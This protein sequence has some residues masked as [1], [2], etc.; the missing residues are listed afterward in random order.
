MGHEIIVRPDKNVFLA[1]ALLHAAGQGPLLSEHPIKEKFT[2]LLKEYKGENYLLPSL[3][4]LALTLNEAPDLSFRKDIS[5]SRNMQELVER[6]KHGQ[7]ALRTFYK[8]TGFEEAYQE[9]L[10]E[11]NQICEEMRKVVAVLKPYDNLDKIWRLT[12]NPFTK[13]VLIPMPLEGIKEASGPSVGD[14]AY[15]IVGPPFGYLIIDEI[16]HEAM[17][18]RMERKIT[19][20]LTE[21][22]E[23]RSYMMGHVRAN[24]FYPPQYGRNWVVC[25]EEHFIRAM[26]V[27]FF[28]ELDFRV[29]MRLDNERVQGFILVKTFYEE[30]DSNRK[31]PNHDLTDV[32]MKILERLDLEYKDKK[33]PPRYVG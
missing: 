17:H 19:E 9:I 11:Y 29:P 3:E 27:A 33:V 25:F 31:G 30:I 20:G 7:K 13:D 16:I 10:P 23:K 5:L 18:P 1:Y 26:Q 12:D 2:S 8:K 28:E 32:A 6:L 14:T 4:V 24:P 22:I 15:Q 21:E